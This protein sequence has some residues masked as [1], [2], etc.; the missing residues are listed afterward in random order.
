MWYVIYFY[1]LLPQLRMHSSIYAPVI[2]NGIPLSSS[3]IK[4]A[5]AGEGARETLQEE[6]VGLGAL[7]HSQTT[8]R[9]INQ[10]LLCSDC[11][12]PRCKHSHYG[13]L[14][15][16][17]VISP[18]TEL[19]GDT[20]QHNK[21]FPKQGTRSA[22]ACALQAPT[23]TPRSLLGGAVPWPFVSGVSCF[24]GSGLR[25]PQSTWL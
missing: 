21:T 10:A 25:F 2:N 14:L 13:Q 11:Q 12:F 4:Q 3:P 9:T 17:H 18:K 23:L 24:S 7:P 5:L 15:P 6:D 19:E 22:H 16:T 8:N 1:Y 20:L